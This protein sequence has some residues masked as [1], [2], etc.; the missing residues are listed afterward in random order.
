[1]TKT[2][3]KRR[4][5]VFDDAL[6]V[7]RDIALADGLDGLTARRIAKEIGCSV[8]TVYNVFGNLDTL[9]LHLNA[10]T[11]DALHHALTEDGKTDD[12]GSAIH[13]LVER[14]MK[15][16]DENANLWDVIFEHMWPKDY[17]IPDW[18]LATIHRL[19]TVLA[20]ALAPLFDEDEDAEKY[21]AATVLWSGLHGIRSLAFTGKLGLVSPDSVRA[22]VDLLTDIFVEG[23]RRRKR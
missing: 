9:I 11:L 19:F 16:T 5:K 1:M 23:L 4:R 3:E 15:F 18:Y 12:L 17:V 6:A 14:Y 21:Q 22:M 10:S 20:D 2:K 8:G 7:A 13:S